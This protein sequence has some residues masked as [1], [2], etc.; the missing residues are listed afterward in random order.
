MESHSVGTKSTLPNGQ[1]SMTNHSQIMI[2]RAV[3][4]VVLIAL[5]AAQISQVIALR[6]H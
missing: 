4:G 1:V 3:A 2:S 5:E 6:R